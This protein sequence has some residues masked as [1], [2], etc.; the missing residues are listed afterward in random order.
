MWM[1]L[2]SAA[3]NRGKLQTRPGSQLA[4]DNALLAEGRIPC[5]HSGKTDLPDQVCKEKEAEQSYYISDSLDVLLFRHL[6]DQEKEPLKPGF[7][8]PSWCLSPIP[9]LTLPPQDTLEHLGTFT[10]TLASSTPRANG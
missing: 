8:G 7:P 10:D 3:K 1:R 4:A 2:A 9:D 6:Y 5:C